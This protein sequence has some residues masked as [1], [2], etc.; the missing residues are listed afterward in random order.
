[1]IHATAIIDDLPFKPDVASFA[2]QYGISADTVI[3]YIKGDKKKPLVVEAKEGTPI[4]VIPSGN[5]GK[6]LKGTTFEDNFTRDDKRYY[7][8]H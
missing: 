5:Q 2:K 7:P 6:G 4:E 3:A 1:M 8:K